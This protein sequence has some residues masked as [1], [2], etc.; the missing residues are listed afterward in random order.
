MRKE[1][2]MPQCWRPGLGKDLSF[3]DDVEH[4]KSV[5]LLVLALARVPSMFDFFLDPVPVCTGRSVLQVRLRI[6]SPWRAW[7][8]S[9]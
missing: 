8:A 6:G 9:R 7:W 4:V 2:S 3:F 1:F 5:V